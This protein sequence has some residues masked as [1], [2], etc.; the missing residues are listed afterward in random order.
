MEAMKTPHLP[1]PLLVHL[2]DS[3][4]GY[5]TEGAPVLRLSCQPQDSS[6]NSLTYSVSLRQG[7]GGGGEHFQK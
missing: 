6:L 5:R 2:S 3:A 1:T 4:R 7:W